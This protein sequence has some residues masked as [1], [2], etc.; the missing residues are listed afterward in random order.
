MK[1]DLCN[2]LLIV[3]EIDDLVITSGR[4]SYKLQFLLA[5][6]V[7]GALSSLVQFCFFLSLANAFIQTPCYAYHRTNIYCRVQGS[8]TSY[9][10]TAIF[11]QNL[12]AEV[13]FLAFSLFSGPY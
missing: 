9:Y 13:L 6:L 8:V 12:N 10:G 11:C 7:Y 3:K 4:S 1:H 5:T 2:L